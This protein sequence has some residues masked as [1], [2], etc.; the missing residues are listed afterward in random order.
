MIDRKALG[1]GLDHLQVQ[2]D[3]VMFDPGEDSEAHGALDSLMRGEEKVEDSKRLLSIHD[4]D[5]DDNTT[6]D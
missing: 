3:Q 1:L 2:E 4:M 5:W 6:K